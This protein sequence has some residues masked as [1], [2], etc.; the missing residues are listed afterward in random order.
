MNTD[1]LV[2]YG[3][4]SLLYIVIFFI[5]SLFVGFFCNFCGVLSNSGCFLFKYFNDKTNYLFR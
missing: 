5:I 2:E 1:K 3:I 4:Y